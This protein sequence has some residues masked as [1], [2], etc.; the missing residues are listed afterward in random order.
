M[1]VDSYR[2][3][4]FATRQVAKA[5]I[6]REPARDI[7]WAPLGKPL[8]EC[9]VAVISSGAIALKSDKPFDQ[10]TERKNPWW[11]DPTHRVIPRDARGED[12]EVYHLHIDTRFVREDLNCLL[13]LELLSDL[14]AGGEIG[15]V[16]GH[17]YSYMGYTLDPTSLLEDTVPKIITG[18][19]ND[20]VDLVLLVPT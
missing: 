7:P 11:G 14:E 16:A 3:V 17:H 1:T 18:L 4:D 13:P 15:P 5:W 8:A 20:E 6:A 2:F 12:L 9:T 19:R 10:E